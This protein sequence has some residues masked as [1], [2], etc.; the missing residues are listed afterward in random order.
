MP[1]MTEEQF[2]HLEAMIK[3]VVESHVSLHV[4]NMHSNNCFHAP[5]EYKALQMTDLEHHIRAKTKEAL[6][7]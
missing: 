4:L 3:A 1:V 5:H 2:S 7:K 6:T